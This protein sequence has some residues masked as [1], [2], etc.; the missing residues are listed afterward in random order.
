MLREYTRAE[1]MRVDDY[2]PVGAGTVVDFLPN[3][4][5]WVTR[6]RRAKDKDDIVRVTVCGDSL[7]DDGVLDGDRA[8]CRL[9]FELGDVTNG[10]LVI[11]KLPDGGL[12]IKKIYLT[13]QGLVC[14]KAGNSNYEDQYF[15]LDEIEVKALVIETVRSWE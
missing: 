11:V 12:T 13:E 14:L 10:R 7:V 8:I 6:P 9:N 5:S 2:G 3:G 4:K 15:E 1:R